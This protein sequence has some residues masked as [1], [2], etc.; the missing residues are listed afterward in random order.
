V[1]IVTWAHSNAPFAMAMPTER[2]EAVLAGMVGAFEFFGCVAREVWWDNPKTVATAILKGRRR[3][4]HDRYAALAS[5]YR[6]DPMFCMPASGQ[7]KPRV[8]NRV[9][10][11]QRRWATPVPAV[12]DLDEL[13]DHLRSCC[14]GERDRT[15][16]GQNQTIGERFEQDRATSLALPA[17]GFDASISTPAK[18]DKYQTVRF[19]TNRYSVPRSFAFETVTVKATIDRIDVVA[20]GGRGGRG[21]VVVASH[22]RCYG[23]DEQI[24]EPLHYLVTLGRRP[25]AL[26]HA[27]VYRNWR[28]PSVF[29]ALRR[30]L[31][32]RHGPSAGAR[33]YIRVLQLLAEHPVE[34]VRA[35]IERSMDRDVVTAELIRD[36]TARLAARSSSPGAA[37]T[38]ATVHRLTVPKPDL[39]RFDQ[40]L[41][42]TSQG[43]PIHA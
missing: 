32:D 13:N 26:D 33:Q 24:L 2:I 14:I 36:R 41:A 10:D 12:N 37:A 16:S 30:L 4:V 21:G 40:L 29:A 18:V 6:F 28:L 17:F 23:S 8:E 38:G 11:L 20:T 9:Y 19:D 25:A 39:N 31:E 3:R 42:S 7:E 22:A 5:H 15:V 27:D 35:V 1:L 34:R 43:E